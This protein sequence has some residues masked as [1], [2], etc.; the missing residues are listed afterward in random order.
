MGDY[1]WLWGWMAACGLCGAIHG[2]SVKLPSNYN[3]P[4]VNPRA[5]EYRTEDKD[6]DGKTETYAKINGKDYLFKMKN[7]NPVL[8]PYEIKKVTE[9]VKTTTITNI[10][11]I[12]LEEK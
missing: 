11:K 6:L 8:V 5:I 9:T 3:A 2:G 7:G 1:G 12:I 4:Y 10:E